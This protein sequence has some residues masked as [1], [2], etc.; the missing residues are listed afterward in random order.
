MPRQYTII[1][2]VVLPDDYT[3]EGQTPELDLSAMENGDLSLDDLITL[4]DADYLNEAKLTITYEVK[5]L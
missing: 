1:Y 2:T 4:V 3:E 5:D